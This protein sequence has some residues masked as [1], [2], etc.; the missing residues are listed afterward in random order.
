MLTPSSNSS[1]RRNSLN[2][3]SS[4]IHQTSQQ[5]L[6][7]QIVQNII[8]LFCTGTIIA[9]IIWGAVYITERHQHKYSIQRDKNIGSDENI[10]TVFSSDNNKQ[11]TFFSTLQT[12]LSSL[13]SSSSQNE[14]FV[15]SSDL[16][17][18]T[19]ISALQKEIQQL[20]EKAKEKETH[21][22]ELLQE[23]QQLTKQMTD[24][25]K[26]NIHLTEESLDQIDETQTTIDARA[27]YVQYDGF[28]QPVQCQHGK[29]E[30]VDYYITT[31]NQMIMWP[32]SNLFYFF[33]SVC[34][35]LI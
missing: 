33:F 16:D 4:A 23:E 27:G 25:E 32:Y 1:S 6:K 28:N 20:K 3:L 11:S 26:I 2:S 10:N 30:I 18:Q 19:M 14:L 34:C 21:M 9:A 15:S 5:R 31:N 13:T 8:L 12:D 7:K 22:T 24:Q 29:Q 17:A 35:F